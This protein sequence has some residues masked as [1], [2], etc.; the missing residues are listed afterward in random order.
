MLLSQI[1]KLDINIATLHLYIPFPSGDLLLV[2]LKLFCLSQ[3][4]TRFLP[5]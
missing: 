3:F 4:V 2:S 1:Q 5:S